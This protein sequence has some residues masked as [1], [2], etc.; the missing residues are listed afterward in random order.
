MYMAKI[1]TVICEKY[2]ITELIGTGGM[3]NVYRAV[4]VNLK[5][6]WAV[7]E[8]RKNACDEVDRI[9]IQSAIVEANMMK[10]LDHP[11]IPRVVDMMENTEAIYV[12]MDYI[13]GDTL[14]KILNREGHLS[15][16]QVLDWAK[17]LCEVLSYL[18]RQAP[19]II[20]RDM[21]PG[22]V[23]ITADGNVI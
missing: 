16:E 15:I 3:S 21:K 19:P 17:A 6:V 20:Y 22:N 14:E 8:I 12:I 2:E 23:I 9:H 7:K 18:H 13:E 5:K 4:D 10:K 1:G 11:A